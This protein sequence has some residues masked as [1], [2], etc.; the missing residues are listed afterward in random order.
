MTR[1]LGLAGLAEH[2]GVEVPMARLRAMEEAL[3]EETESL[4]VSPAALNCLRGLIRRGVKILIG[5]NLALPYGVALRHALRGAGLN[6]E[7]LGGPSGIACAFSYEMGLIKPDPRFYAAIAA[8]APR[9]ALFLM[10]GDKQQEDHDA[11]VAQGWAAAPARLRAF[12]ASEWEVIE[13]L[14]PR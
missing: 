2:Y 3:F 1:P 10:V 11:P 14:F 8:S 9:T 7:R 13:G 12:D 6:P 4:I 5:S